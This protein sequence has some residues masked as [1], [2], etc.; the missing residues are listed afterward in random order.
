MEAEVATKTRAS[1]G[2]R[3][4]ERTTYRNCYRAR[5]WGTRVGTLDLQVP[6]VRVGSYFPSLLEPRRRLAGALGLSHSSA[7]ILSK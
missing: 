7:F 3:S 2:G 4:S 5:P 1:L 6:K